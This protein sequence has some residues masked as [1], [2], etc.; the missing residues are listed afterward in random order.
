MDDTVFVAVSEA[1]RLVNTGSESKSHGLSYSQMNSDLVMADPTL[2]KPPT[3]H[4]D[5]E[6]WQNWWQIHLPL[7]LTS[8]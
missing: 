2:N 6:Q 4:L 3:M 5:G 7:L 1:K 8:R